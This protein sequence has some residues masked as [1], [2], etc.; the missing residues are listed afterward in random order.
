MLIYNHRKELIGIDETDLNK[1]GFKNLAE[2]NSEVSDFADLFIKKPGFIH[3]FKHVHWIDFI[4]A[5]DDG[6][7]SRVNIEAKGKRYNANIQIKSIYLS[8]EPSLNGYIIYLHQLYSEDQDIFD[9]P[10]V[11]P[12]KQN[13]KIEEKV[14]VQEIKKEPTIDKFK[15]DLKEK[16]NLDLNILDDENEN[17]DLDV[18]LETKHIDKI[19]LDIKEDFEDEIFAIEKKVPIND[20][21]IDIS[22]ND[23]KEP[24]DTLE[25]AQ[26]DIDSNYVYDPHIASEELGLPI[27]LVEE[28][29]GDFI[30][31]AKEFKEELYTSLTHS[32]FEN[33]KNLS[34]KLKGVAANLRIDDAFEY[35]AV[36]NTSN[37]PSEIKH[38]LNKFYK[39]ISKLAGEPTQPTQPTKKEEP[40]IEKVTDSIELDDDLFIKPEQIEISDDEVEVEDDLD[41]LYYKQLVA[42]ELG[43]S[44]EIFNELLNDFVE[45]AKVLSQSMENSLKQNDLEHS[46]KEAI[47]LKGMSENMRLKE[48][49]KDLESIITSTDKEIALDSLKNINNSLEKYIIK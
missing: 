3:N 14:V 24:Y 23:I 5:S 15:D 32:D 7:I 49:S 17:I 11:T 19:E 1:L 12:I 10:I 27:D 34:H 16:A 22:F 6:S 2:L 9:E 30:L 48:F 43:L 18:K 39:V 26:D 35:L 20:E 31:Q 37:N 13:T 42:S 25:D 45:E 36:I 29:I 21:A 46:K 40:K 41:M 47:K 4:K 28:F 33:V 38:N 44:D 8:D